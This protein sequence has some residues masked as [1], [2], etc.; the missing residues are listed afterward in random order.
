[1][2]TFNDLLLSSRTI[3]IGVDYYDDDD[4]ACF[5]RYPQAEQIQGIAGKTIS[6]PVSEFLT[7]SL[8]VEKRA[9]IPHLRSYEAI[10]GDLNRYLPMFDAGLEI[11]ERSLRTVLTG[12][13]Q[14]FDL[15]EKIGSGVAL[16]VTNRLT[17]LTEA[18]WARIPVLPHKSFDYTFSAP[19]GHLEVEAKGSSVTDNTGAK[20]D[21]IVRHAADIRGKFREPMLQAA[22]HPITRYGVIGAIDQRPDGV[23]KSWLVDPPAGALS[24]SPRDQQIIN[25]LCFV[26]EILEAIVPDA[27][28]LVDLYKRI[29]ALSEAEDISVFHRVPLSGSVESW[30]QALYRDQ[31][32]EAEGRFFGTILRLRNGTQFFY[33]LHRDWIA[34]AQR[35][36]FGVI[37]SLMFQPGAGLVE[38]AIPSK[39]VERLME[40]RRIAADRANRDL[41]VVAHIQVA[42]SGR[43]FGVV[44]DWLSRRGVHVLRDE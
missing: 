30:T 25:R 18:D 1:M 7:Y 21:M 15:S 19:W 27:Y 28:Q 33:G 12:N 26:A 42:S 9:A 44:D 40:E 2:G 37:S 11:T 24:R 3:D 16:S 4:R 8:F 29:L 6:V 35:Q 38:M 14:V 43:V 10:R 34:A 13:E 32:R 17:G 36:D 23:L 41:F 22:K 39:F 31:P 5:G 20:A